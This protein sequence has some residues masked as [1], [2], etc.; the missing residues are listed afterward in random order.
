MAL[1]N[2]KDKLMQFIGKYKYMILVLLIGLALIMLPDLKDETIQEPL[3]EVK[4]KQGGSVNEEL[5]NI[6][7]KIQGAGDVHVYLTIAA[8]EKTIYQ[9]DEDYSMHTD[10]STTKIE[11]VIVSSSDRGQSGLIQQ[12]NPPQYLGALIVCQGADSPAVQLSIVDA[13]SKITGLGTNCISV[14]KMK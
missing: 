10:T 2:I 11:T 7:S 6:L 9:T 5:S 3:S 8:G 13:V 14:L 4:P 1:K 12:V